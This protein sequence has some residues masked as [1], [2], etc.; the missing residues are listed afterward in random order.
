MMTGLQE[1]LTTGGVPVLRLHYSADTK[2][3]PGT[4]AGDA[5]LAQATQGY[6]GGTQSPRWRK[7]YEIDYGAISG[8]KL[9]PLWEQ[10]KGNGRIVIPPFD[11]KGYRLYG[12]YDH[13]WRHPAAYHVHGINGDGQVVTLF[14]FFDSHVP[15]HIVARIIKG[16][17]VRAP[18]TGCTC[19]G[20]Q[21]TRTFLG[22]PYAGQELVKW[23]DP[24]MWAE[25]QLQSDGANKSM[26][27]LFSQA[28]VHFLEGQRG[29]DTTMAEWLLG[30]YWADPSNPTYRLTTACPALIRE[31]GLQR[32]KD[33]SEK[34][35]LNRAQPE[36]LVDKD[37]DAWDSLKQFLMQF[38]PTP[39]TAQPAKKAC[40]FEWWAQASRRVSDGEP[41]PT[42]QREV[43]G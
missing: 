36:A 11:P 8:T 41:M 23:A 22:N 18:P 32:H 40:T 5:W 30:H 38:P 20:H 1:R 10:W 12:S 31:I 24:S 35:A 3:R 17:T 34:V 4:E 16:E 2:K 14:E 21:Q 37:N 6:P 33:V 13:G 39:Q 19:K 28:G 26:A 7:E 9:I 27:H 15:Y 25:D 42:F 43:V 29:G